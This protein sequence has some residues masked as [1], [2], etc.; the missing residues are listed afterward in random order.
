MSDE[1]RPEVVLGRAVRIETPKGAPA[2]SMG[3]KVVDAETGH[4]VPLVRDIDIR[5]RV[6]EAVTAKLVSYAEV[7]LEARVDRHQHIVD[8]CCCGRR[9]YVDCGLGEVTGHEVSS[10]ADVSDV[11]TLKDGVR[12]YK[13]KPRGRE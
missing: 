9:I 11:T 10:N 5:I 6:D 8:C 3:T 1:P 13:P 7:S 2:L 4:P 12:S